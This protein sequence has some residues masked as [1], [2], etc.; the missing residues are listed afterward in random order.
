MRNLLIIVLGLLCIS[1]A[2]KPPVIATGPDVELTYDGLAPIENSAFKKAWAAPDIDLT[3]YTKIMLGRAEF[4]FRAVR[5]GG[6]RSTQNEFEISDA[7]RQKL[8]DV[9]SEVFDE[10]VA[11]NIRFEITDTPGAD[12]LILR[13]AVL[14]VVSNVPPE[15]A[16]R[17]DIYLVRFG[18]ATIVLELVDSMSNETLVRA[19]ERSAADA[20]GGRGTRANSVTSW[21]EVKR[22]AR[23]WATKLR[24]GLDAV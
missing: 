21:N 19:A 24:N 13:G 5:G 4:E 1:C 2:S 3:R 11:K 16:G 10:E 23:R 18:E 9:V 12:V 17:N 8:I 6:S 7:N 20:P 22:M 15:R 14:D